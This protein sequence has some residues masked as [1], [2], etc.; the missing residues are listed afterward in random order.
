MHPNLY[1]NDLII[2]SVRDRVIGQM[3]TLY[4]CVVV[5]CSTSRAQ[6]AL[7]DVARVHWILEHAI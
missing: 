6:L 3:I 5:C 4:M 2:N 7:H 1:M